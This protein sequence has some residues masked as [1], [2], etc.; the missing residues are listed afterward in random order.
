MIHY[1]H[2]PSCVLMM[3]PNGPDTS[4]PTSIDP[5]LACPLVRISSLRNTR[6]FSSIA[7]TNPKPK[8]CSTRRH[9]PSSPQLTS[10]RT[11]PLL[12]RDLRLFPLEVLTTPPT[13]PSEISDIKDSYYPKSPIQHRRRDRNVLPSASAERTTQRHSTGTD[14]TAT[15]IRSNVVDILDCHGWLV[16][17]FPHLLYLRSGQA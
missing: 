14:P 7:A 11:G 3:C 8:S 12:P 9:Q 17:S 4:T 16:I 2:L 5:S 15:Q 6:P 13:L 1:I 10:H